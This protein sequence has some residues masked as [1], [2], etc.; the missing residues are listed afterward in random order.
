MPHQKVTGKF[1]TVERLAF[2]SRRKDPP[3]PNKPPSEGGSFLPPPQSRSRRPKSL[4]DFE[5]ARCRESTNAL[6]DLAI[7]ERPYAPNARHRGSNEVSSVPCFATNF[8]LN[9]SGPERRIFVQPNAGKRHVEGS[10]RKSSKAK[11]RRARRKHTPATQ[12]PRSTHSNREV[13]ETAGHELS[14][15]S[16]TRLTR[17]G[18]NSDATVAGFRNI[19][20][21]HHLSND[22]RF[23]TITEV[24]ERVSVATRT[25]RRWIEAGA[26]VAH[27]ICGVVRIA[28]SDL[29]A[30][31]A[32][33][34]EG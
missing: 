2:S 8:C 28:E 19:R 27:R 10:S 15:S 34:R 6:A 22:I 33:H 1:P 32:L 21:R 20:G 29:R 3:H 24:A 7:Q 26:L 11:S 30:F 23:F 4:N 25:V 12:Q 13:A 5:V 14:V 31:L 17:P 16:D 9:A 18:G